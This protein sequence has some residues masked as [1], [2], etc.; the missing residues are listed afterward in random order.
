MY[1]GDKKKKMAMGG[2]YI[3]AQSNQK[4]LPGGMVARGLF[5][6]AK[7]LVGQMFDDKKGVNLGPVSY[8][9]LT[10]PTI[11]RV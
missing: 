9:H 1:H 10:L 8:T 3:G 4:M 7:N 5:G 2:M 11:L 6:A